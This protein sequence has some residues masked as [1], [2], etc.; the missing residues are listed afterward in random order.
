MASL[1]S[2]AL[3]RP[4]LDLDVEV[5]VGTRRSRRQVAL[6]C[7]PEGDRIGSSRADTGMLVAINPRRSFS[8][9]FDRGVHWFQFERDTF[10]LCLPPWM[11]LQLNTRNW[12]SQSVSGAIYLSRSDLL[13]A[14]GARG[15]L[16]LQVLKAAPNRPCYTSRHE[17]LDTCEVFDPLDGGL[18]TEYRRGDAQWRGLKERLEVPPQTRHQLRRVKAGFSVNLIQ[19]YGISCVLPGKVGAVLDMSDHRYC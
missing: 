13:S 15:V 5:I 8:S 10:A 1:V 18:G 7:A 9:R 19:M 11:D 6:A 17:H 14:L 12:R 2:L 16:L 4:T 3:E